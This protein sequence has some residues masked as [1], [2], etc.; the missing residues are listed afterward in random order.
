[1]LL[2]S[3]QRTS[4]IFYNRKRLFG[5]IFQETRAHFSNPSFLVLVARS[6]SL[7]CAANDSL[8]RVLKR[9]MDVRI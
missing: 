8:S 3:V 2:F 6:K 1:M 5:V 7:F 9:L 4:V